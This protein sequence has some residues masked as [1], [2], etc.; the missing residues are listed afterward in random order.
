[1]LLVRDLF[2]F[3][4]W[5]FCVGK[6]YRTSVLVRKLKLFYTIKNTK[7]PRVPSLSEMINITRSLKNLS[8]LDPVHLLEPVYF[9]DSLDPLGSVQR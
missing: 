7:K 4:I 3:A 8:Y 6:Y 2:L 1:M 9:S 5:L